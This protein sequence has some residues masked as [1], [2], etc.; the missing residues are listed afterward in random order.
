MKINIR[1]L[2]VLLLAG[3]LLTSCSG[4]NNG[5]F[6]P[7]SN[8]AVFATFVLNQTNIGVGQQV[9]LNIA[10]NNPNNHSLEFRFTCDRGQITGQNPESPAANYIAPFSGGEDTIRVSVFD[11][12]DN[13]NLPQIQQRILVFGD[14][15][16]FV[17]LPQDATALADAD[18][19]VIKVTGVGGSSSQPRQ[20]AVGRQPAISPDGRYL[21]YT[22]YPGDGTSQIRVQD[23]AGNI[24]IV[25]GTSKAFNRDPA[26]API[27]NDRQ[28]YLAFASDRIS[29]R[30]GQGFDERGED[31]NIW[32]VNALG[33]DIRQLTSTPGSDMEPT[34]SPDGRFL[35]YRSNFAQNK[36]NNFWNL[37]RME[38]MSGRLVQ[39]T[40]ETAPE[41]GTYQPSFSPDGNRIVY[42]RQYLNRQPQNLFNF[43]KIWMLDMSKLDLPSLTP[44]GTPTVLPP[45]ANGINPV[46]LGNFGS[47]TNLNGNFG[48]I[49]TQ[50]FDE[51]TVESS[52]SFSVDGRLIY[53]VR[54]RAQ[55]YRAVGVPSNPGNLGTIGLE[56]MAVPGVER[57]TEVS[58]ARQ[59]RSFGNGL[60]I[61]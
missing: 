33:Q 41:K 40:Y 47:E 39:L 48:Q 9:P 34:W 61:F 60:G 49:V 2:S 43:R 44:G 25:S 26:W 13:A 59:A 1:R 22:Y 24:T 17:E 7:N 32:R 14:G 54:A 37:W 55:E 11:R 56:P 6:F 20:V 29:S 18:N 23:A 30:T 50:E 31:F 3:T 42:V 27:G 15:V 52:P 57:A 16:A 8:V 58:W 12:N 46:P 36:V 38:M 5:G 4:N 51:G 21:A 35:V 10:V 19:G 28:Q 45:G 53:Y